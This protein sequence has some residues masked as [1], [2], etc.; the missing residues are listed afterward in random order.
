MVAHPPL[1]T[2]HEAL[3][4]ALKLARAGFH[5]APVRLHW[6]PRLN[7]KSPDYLRIRW[8]D[9]ASMDPDV[10]RHW[11]VEHGPDLS[12]LVDTGRSG[13]FGVDLDVPS[14]A[15][16]FTGEDVWTRA[17]LPTS[18]MMVRTPG[19][20]LHHYWRQPQGQALTV[21]KRVH[22][23]PID[24]RAVGGHLFAPGAVV[25]NPDG[26]AR[27]TYQLLTEL[28]PAAELPT[29]PEVVREFLKARQG[30][31]DKRPPAQGELRFRH[32]V[33]DICRDQLDRVRSSAARTES[34]FRDKL[35]GAS[36]VLGRAVAA[37]MTNRRGAER[38]LREAV[39]AVWGAVNEDDARWIR[40]GLDDGEQD[41]WTV[42]DDDYD[43]EVPRSTNGSAPTSVTEMSKDHGP[44][45]ALDNAEVVTHGEPST[46]DGRNESEINSTNAETAEP[47]GLAELEESDSWAPLGTEAME[48][49]LS[50][51]VSAP[52]PAVG[53][54]RSDGHRFL[55]PG[56]E[57]A[58]IGEMEAGKSWFALACCAAELAAG[59]RVVYVHFEESDA[60]STLLRLNR[61]FR[62]PAAVLLERF[63]F[64][65][66][67]RRVTP[68]DVDR[69]C[70]DVPPS[71]TVLD[72]VNEAMALHGQKIN[73]AEGAAEYRRRIVR[74][75][76]RRG[77]SVLSLDHVPKDPDGRAA[78]YAYGSVHK[79]N[80]L[81]GAMIML[82]N[83]EPFG[84]GRLGVSSV[85]VTKDRH[86]QLRQL[87]RP[88]ESASSA[89]R[90]FFLGSF[91]IDDRSEIWSAS[92]TP[93]V[94]PDP[95][96]DPEFAAMRL[97]RRA[98]ERAT[99]VETEVLAAVHGFNLK[100]VEPSGEMVKAAVRRDR[101]AVREALALMVLD[102]RLIMSEG[103]RGTKTYSVADPDSV[104]LKEDHHP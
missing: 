100:R 90:K 18:P 74:P 64:V 87:G 96:E 55:Y 42:V 72:G 60:T 31:A 19:G 13:V 93:P 11:W 4:L 17:E 82:E 6:N 36:M 80:G 95:G 45:F 15:G 21:H 89:N 81:D 34:G 35:L 75:F 79:G 73:D 25:L 69:L 85:Y 30:D 27:G 9:Q 29:L 83:R 77:V 10:V 1:A 102:G 2:S 20:G 104:I 91:T 61:Q 52:E 44:A 59:H 88:S 49:I 3:D 57:H 38:R 76:T 8:H 37:G 103:N 47:D 65:G 12:Y 46:V 51:T 62:V 39:A 94:P 67:E 78:G 70:G 98:A 54:V 66:P 56:R 63:R 53:I 14:E 48:A 32:Q 22:G 23:L 40:D 5:L 58:L 99:E 26:S 92:F 16:R 28:V 84:I 50:G 43:T 97:E 41:P 101:N 33:V 71:L 86:G 24:V 68:A 7:R